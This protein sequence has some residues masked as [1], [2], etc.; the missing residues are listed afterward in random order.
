[1]CSCYIPSLS[2]IL[3]YIDAG[4]VVSGLLSFGWRLGTGASCRC[5]SPRRRMLKRFQVALTL[6][7][8]THLQTC[9]RANGSMHGQKC[10]FIMAL[11]FCCSCIPCHVIIVECLFRLVGT[12]NAFVSPLY[13]LCRLPLTVLKHCVLRPGQFFYYD[14]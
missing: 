5:W 1:M 12:I 4:G 13:V 6:V 3:V 10:H 9:C 2:Y 8:I 11:S 14:F 7:I